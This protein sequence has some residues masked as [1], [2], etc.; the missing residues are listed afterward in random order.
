MNNIIT[1]F[2]STLYK[3]V[4]TVWTVLSNIYE[5]F[6]GIFNGF[7]AWQIWE[8][9][10]PQDIAIVLQSLVYV[11]IILAIVGLIKKAVLILG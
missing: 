6:V 1:T 11:L 8:N 5:R 9:Y 10:V 2:L 3:G 7:P 4:D